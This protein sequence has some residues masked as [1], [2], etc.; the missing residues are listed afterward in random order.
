MI[1]SGSTLASKLD[2]TAYLLNLIARHD[3]CTAKHAY[4]VENI[5]VQFAKKLGLSA[6][7]IQDIS[8]A[9]LLHDIGKMAVPKQILNKSGNL[10]VTEFE[11]IKKHPEDGF[12]F[13]KT[14]DQFDHIAEAILYHHEKFDG[15]GYP[16]GKAGEAI[17]L[18]SRIL[19]ISDVYEA[20]TSNRV[21]RK[22]MTQEEARRVISN[23]KGTHF[24]PVL[25]DIF[26]KR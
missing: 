17:P 12:N 5:A 15:N 9:A 4:N 14:I 7:Y 18:I 16:Y 25:V 23:G 10:T 11:I 1:V 26:L 8:T 22:A 19:A 21:Y 2:I 13:L 3:P 24:D 6:Q 20:I